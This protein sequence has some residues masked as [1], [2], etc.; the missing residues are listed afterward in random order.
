M[1]FDRLFP[2][3]LEGSSLEGGLRALHE[4]YAEV[5]AATAAFQAQA[6]AFLE[7]S[8]KPRL[9]CPEGC[10]SCCERFIP[11]IHRVEAEYAALWIIANDEGLGELASR[12]QGGAC[13]FYARDRPE[14]HCGIYG[15][16]P[17]ICRLFGYSAVGGKEGDRAYSLCWRMP[18]P[19]GSD[20]RSWEG[21]ALGAA[22]GAEPPLMADF[23]L[24]L[25]AISAPEEGNKPLMGEALGLALGRLRLLLSLSG[26]P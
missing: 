1:D 9:G 26:R 21:P 23:G 13:P 3:A 17:L 15:G 4:L 5:D 19:L 25:Y 2:K 18:S 14:A 7:A 6:N 22:L 16:R 8:D 20:A 24:R 12:D 10:G 11:D